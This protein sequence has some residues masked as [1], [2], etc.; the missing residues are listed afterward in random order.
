MNVTIFNS[1][2]SAQID[3]KGAELFSLK[4]IATNQ[5]YMWEGDP[6]F[7]E[8]HSP[9]LFPIVGTLKNNTFTYNENQFQL[10]RHGLAR[11]LNFSLIDA[12]ENQAVFS[13]QSSEETKKSYP[14]EFELQITYTLLDT[15]LE[16]K[17]TII[18]NDKVAMPFSIGAHPA[19]A[20]PNN[21]ESYALEFDQQE[22]L[23]CFTLENDLVSDNSFEIALENKKL[24]LTY[25]TFEN[26]ALIFKTL[27]SRVIT[28]LKNNKPILKV[29]FN[30][31]KNLGIWTKVGASFICIEP[32][33]GY[34]DT[35]HATGN[36]LE[37]E[38][39]QFVAVN[40]RF[41]C[42]FSVEIL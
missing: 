26:D 28:I 31:F 10:L 20:L 24:P 30:D 8:K 13:L 33:L 39:I 4:S 9:V 38:G 14:F 32:W 42:G 7:W 19:F 11:N 18:N 35:I 29:A 37:K 12:T 22:N 17:Y 40:E 34:S 2:L 5:E 36:L 16:L 3:C 21:F 1:K 25:S 6:K 15:K 41:E 23:K 27:Q